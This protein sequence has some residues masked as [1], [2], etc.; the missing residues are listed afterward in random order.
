MLNKLKNWARRLI[1]SLIK[2]E[3]EALLPKGAPNPLEGWQ[4]N[5][6]L[7]EKPRYRDC[8]FQPHRTIEGYLEVRYFND[9]KHPKKAGIKY[10]QHMDGASPEELKEYLL[11]LP[12][13]V[14]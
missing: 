12:E 7:L 4:V 3:V 9:P 11:R 6:T 14:I 2:E 1:W 10:P 8:F 5:T 13:A